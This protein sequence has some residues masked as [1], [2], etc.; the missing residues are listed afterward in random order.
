[1]ASSTRARVILQ[2]TAREDASRG[3]RPRIVATWND[4]IKRTQTRLGG[5]FSRGLE[6]A[7]GGI[8]DRRRTLL[9]DRYNIRAQKEFERFKTVVWCARTIAGVSVG[10]GAGG[11]RRHSRMP[12]SASVSSSSVSRE[13]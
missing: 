10:G 11:F 4:L 13:S 3:V 7:T 5:S 1:M 12:A 2:E 6:R 9:I 8:S